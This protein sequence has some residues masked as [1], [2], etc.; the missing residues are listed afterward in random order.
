MSCK[1][2]LSLVNAASTSVAVNT[3]INLGNSVRRRGIK[4]CGDY[5][6]DYN[7]AGIIINKPGYYRFMAN[8]TFTS[9]SAGDVTVTLLQNG[10]PVP[11]YT[12][13]TTITT[14]A[15]QVVNLA[16][17]APDV[18]VY[19]GTTPAIFTLVVSGIG[20]TTSN[21]AVSVLEV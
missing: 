3:A 14:A 15:T 10:V 11:G 8:L 9:P 1:P 6:I 18:R 7:G 2:E 21:V 17:N 16:L 13:T 4:N 12:A 19:C 5:P 20:I